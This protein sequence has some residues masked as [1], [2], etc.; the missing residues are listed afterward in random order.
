MKHLFLYAAVFTALAIPCRPAHAQIDRRTLKPAMESI[1]LYLSQKAAVNQTVDIDT[2]FI[3]KRSIKVHL[4][5]AISDYP[6]RDSEL[7]FMENV[8]RSPLPARC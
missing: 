8:L 2:F 5:G 6:L 7:R 4:N 3:T 1:N